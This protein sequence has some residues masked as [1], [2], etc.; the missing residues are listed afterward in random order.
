MPSQPLNNFKIQKYYQIEPK[1][2]GIYSKNNLSNMKDGT[3]LINLDGYESLGTHWIPL[4]V[5]SKHWSW[6]RRTEDVLKTFWRRLQY[7]IFLSSKTSS[8]HNSKTSNTLLR[9]N[10]NSFLTSVNQTL[11]RYI[12]LIVLKIEG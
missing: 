7:N 6:W 2:D 9:Y 5:P 1:F 12:F 4:Y 8:R 3:Y 10:R 11:G